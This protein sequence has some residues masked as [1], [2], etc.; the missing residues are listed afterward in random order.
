MREELMNRMIRLYG[1]ENPI[2]IDFCRLCEEW[3]NTE[4]Y[5][6]ALVHWSSATKKRRSIS[7][8]SELLLFARAPAQVYTKIFILYNFLKNT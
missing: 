6:N 2:T 4:A 8:R 1:F 7:K 3:P 5:D